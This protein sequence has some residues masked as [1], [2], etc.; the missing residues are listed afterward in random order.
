MKPFASL[1]AAAAILSGLSTLPA[2]AA[3]IDIR[4]LT[5]GQVQELVRQQGAIVLTFTNTTYDRVVRSRAFCARD[6]NIMAF[7]QNTYDILN[8]HIGYQC[9]R[10]DGFFR[11]Y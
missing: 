10:D 11:K 7:H 6:E 9:V 5:C 1:A 3:R 8:C 2:E 4:T